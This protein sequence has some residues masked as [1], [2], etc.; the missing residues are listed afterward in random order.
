M[1][2]GHKRVSE[3][4]SCGSSVQIAVIYYCQ[5]NYKYCTKR[6]YKIH[7]EIDEIY[8]N[9]WT[10]RKTCSFSNLFSEENRNDKNMKTALVWSTIYRKKEIILKQWKYE[11]VIKL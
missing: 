6:Q 11:N 1:F 10:N 9:V 4:L 2:L 5:K 7:T 3:K 8:I